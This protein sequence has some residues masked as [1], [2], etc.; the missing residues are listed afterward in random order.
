LLLGYVVAVE[1]AYVY[2]RGNC[3]SGAEEGG[4]EGEMHG[5]CGVGAG[6]GAVSLCGGSCSEA[7]KALKD[8]A[9]S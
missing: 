9:V 4:G 6:A 3:C 2:G 7:C 5:W 1:R 8:C